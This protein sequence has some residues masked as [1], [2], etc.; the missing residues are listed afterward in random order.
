M[1]R[2]QRRALELRRTLG[3]RGRVDAE[4]V[5]NHLGLEVKLWTLRVLKE[6]GIGD[7]I[8]VARRLDPA[9]RRWVTA[10][11]IGHRLLHPG[12]HLW[13]RLHTGL[14]QRYER[15]AEDFARALLVDAREAE[16]AGLMES[17]E[18]AEHFGVPDE[19]LSLHNAPGDQ[20]RSVS[21][22]SP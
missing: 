21:S 22:I 2:A 10:H 8:C 9:W 1:N 12:N 13:I 11:A 7:V 17:W 6:M 18:V 15:E 5:T 4:A 14:A 3:L 16:A 19:V 20:L